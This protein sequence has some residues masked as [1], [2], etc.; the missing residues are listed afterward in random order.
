MGTNAVNF[1]GQ[2]PYILYT[3]WLAIF[4][5]T[6]VKRNE[7][8]TIAQPTPVSVNNWPSDQCLTVANKHQKTTLPESQK[9][10]VLIIG[11][12]GFMTGRQMS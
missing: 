11:E 4:T 2:Y 3:K 1:S 12:K 10:T 7:V 8:E 6:H 9:Q 5:S